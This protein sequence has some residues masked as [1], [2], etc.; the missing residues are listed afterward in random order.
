[1]HVVKRATDRL[2]RRCQPAVRNPGIRSACIALSTL[3]LGMSSPEM[4]RQ[5]TP[6]DARLTTGP[7]GI[8][9]LSRPRGMAMDKAG[10]LFIADSQ[11]HRVLKATAAGVLSPVAGTGTAGFSGDGGS[12]LSAQLSFPQDVDL[13]PAGNLYIADAGNQRVRRVNPEGIITTLPRSIEPLSSSNGPLS[14]VP[15]T[16]ISFVQDS[17]QCRPR[18]GGP[19]AG[20]IGQGASGCDD[21]SKLQRPCYRR[22]W[23]CVRRRHPSQPGEAHRFKRNAQYFCRQRHERFQWRPGTRSSGTAQ[24]S[25]RSGVGRWR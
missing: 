25:D 9:G 18:E 24:R 1:M 16:G 20:G 4:A 23:K 15:V 8:V 3:W 5:Q 12:A 10:N 11:S 22:R 21:Y 13:D 19:S 17:S 2:L 6:Q 7:A 14:K